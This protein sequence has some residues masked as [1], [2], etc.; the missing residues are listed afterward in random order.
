MPAV[1]RTPFTGHARAQSAGRNPDPKPRAQA[2]ARRADAEEERAEEALEEGAQL[3]SL[4]IAANSALEAGA[5]GADGEVG[6]ALCRAGR[7]LLRAVGDAG[8]ARGAG[9]AFACHG[10]CEPAPLIA[11]GARA[12]GMPRIVA[13]A[14][15][16][17]QAPQG[18][19]YV[20]EWQH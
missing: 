5:A 17:S 1:R 6:P 4:L 20:C 12:S 8:W 14:P 18:Q 15:T 11:S 2:A 7:A 13:A 9:D 19:V 10:A 16:A 3:R